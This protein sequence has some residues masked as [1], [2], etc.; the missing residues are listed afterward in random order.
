MSQLLLLNVKFPLGL[1]I[2][3][4]IA[5]ITFRVA[6]QEGLPGGSGRLVL[7]NEERKCQL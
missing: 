5:S 7:K 6:S 4:F 2:V 1:S 3:I